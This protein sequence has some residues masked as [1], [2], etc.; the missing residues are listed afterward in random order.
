MIIFLILSICSSTYACECVLVCMYVFV[1]LFSITN[2]IKLNKINV[3]TDE[4]ITAFISQ[5][6]TNNTPD[7]KTLFAKQEHKII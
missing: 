3:L 6:I 1:C 7:I 5:N 4:T 2:F